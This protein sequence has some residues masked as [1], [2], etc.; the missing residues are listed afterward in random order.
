MSQGNGDNKP[1]AADI[2]ALANVSPAT[3]SRVI[4]NRPNV[5][6]AT[7]ERV[8]GIMRQF[9]YGLASNGL[10]GLIIPD[11]SNPYFAN[12]VFTFQDQL[13]KLGAHVIIGSSEGRADKELALVNKFKGLGLK[14]VI[15]VCG[16]RPGQM[17]LQALADD[18]VPVLLFDRRME[19]GN[20]DF[21]A[22]DSRVGM[23]RAV[24]YLVS[25]GHRRIGHLKGL[26]GTRTAI[27]RYEAF[28]D[29][30]ARN[31]IDVVE[32]WIWDGDYSFAAGRSCAE[33]LL[34][35]DPGDRPSA[36]VAGND[37]MAI[38]LVQRLQQQGWS[39]P[40]DLSV[41]GFD[42]IA[43]GDW[44]HPRLTTV[45]QP[46]DVLAWNAIALLMERIR[47]HELRPDVPLEPKLREVQPMLIPR[48]STAPP[49]GHATATRDASGTVVPLR[50]PANDRANA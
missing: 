33:L 50:P 32:R 9:G 12:L 18:N 13:D 39:L 7:R 22:V 45:E 27:D 2:A 48:D 38:G 6:T 24:D 34:E 21:V 29:A 19:D 20:L 10:I 37:A 8:M 17:V 11:S 26:E 28:G 31:R 15:Y 4:N 49:G 42:N 3:V 46:V 1:T 30:L 14:G 23:L 44:I 41:I 25:L 16:G 47:H 43:I 40:A 36:V 35:L 5:S